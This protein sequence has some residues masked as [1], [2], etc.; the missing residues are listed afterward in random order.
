M[1]DTSISGARVAP[2]LDV[3]ARGSDKPTCIAS[4]NGTEFT[5]LT[6]MEWAHQNDG[7]VALY[8]P[9]QT[10]IEWIYEKLQR[11]LAGWT[12]RRGQ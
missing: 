2:E 12:A 5:T 11:K 3:L 1:A 6:I 9:R 8:R 7:R 10:E 4:D